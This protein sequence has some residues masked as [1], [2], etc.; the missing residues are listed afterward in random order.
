[1]ERLP[2]F[3]GSRTVG[4]EVEFPPGGGV[5]EVGFR[6]RPELDVST[7]E[8]KENTPRPIMQVHFRCL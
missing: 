2:G 1:L 8:F 6:N 3:D 7:I 5:F 4:E